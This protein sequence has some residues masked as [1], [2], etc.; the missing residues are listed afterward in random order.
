MIVD[1]RLPC[2]D[3]SQLFG[4]QT[5]SEPK[6]L[7]PGR[8]LQL[9]RLGKIYHR[10]TGNLLLE[11]TDEMCASMV[12]TFEGPIPLDWSH[13]SSPGVAET[14]TQAASLGEIVQLFA[15][16]GKGLFGWPLY[17]QRGLQVLAENGP[18]LYTSPE[19][20]PSAQVY[21]RTTGEV[22]GAGQIH[23]VAL[24]NRPVQD[25]LERVMLA[26]IPGFSAQ[27]P[28][29][30]REEKEEGM[31][32]KASASADGLAKTGEAK[33]DEVKLGEATMTEAILA[34]GAQLSAIRAHIGMAEDKAEDD[35]DK[36]KVEDDED[37]EM[38][39]MAE[40]IKAALAKGDLQGVV[41][42]AE[43]A[44]GQAVAFLTQFAID[45]D[46]RM[47]ALERAALVARRDS[48][49]DA[50]GLTPVE[51]KFA[52]SIY[53]ASPALLAEWQKVREIGPLV[54]GQV[55]HGQ[56]RPVMLRE[57]ADRQ[58]EADR[59]LAL[60]SKDSGDPIAAILKL[61]TERPELFPE[62]V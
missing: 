11:V 37:K 43:G 54:L 48:E 53:N 28:A 42:L 16:P 58:A 62:V 12:E 14:T 41:K 17:N 24:T 46:R 51:R 35:E 47:R 18:T 6:G 30:G 36:D 7:T 57:L 2:F 10:L 33:V 1:V 21:D 29:I 15:V 40:E 22:L 44:N 13:G 50:L 49:L 32:A 55:S 23:A 19:F 26:E 59:L 34:I 39:K 31:P 45:Q 4:P 27:P 5:T 52:E 25:R 8:P 38:P 9:L 60:A 61:A 20:N 56:G 3:E